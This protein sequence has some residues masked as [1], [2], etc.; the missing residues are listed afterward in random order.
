MSSRPLQ[1]NKFGNSGSSSATKYGY[2]K[3][4]NGKEKFV[5]GAA[6]AR[7]NAARKIRRKGNKILMPGDKIRSQQLIPLNLSPFERFFAGLLKG[8][9][10]DFLENDVDNWSRICIRLRLPVP[11]GPIKHYYND[12]K[13]HFSY[14]AALVIEEARYGIAQGIK[15]WQRRSKNFVKA[16]NMNN[17]DNR[18]KK[19]RNQNYNSRRG[20]VKNSIILTLTGA[21]VREKTGHCTM[22]FVKEGGAKFTL[23]EVKSLRQGTVFAC[24]NED[25]APTVANSVL[26]CLLSANREEIIESK[27]F[28]IMVFKPVKKSTDSTWQLIP[29]ASLLTEQRKFDACTSNITSTVPFLLP[30]LGGKK[31]THIKFAEK[32][33]GELVPED[34]KMEEEEK[35]SEQELFSHDELSPLFRSPPL[36]TTQKKAA[37]TFLNSQANTITLIQGPPGTG[38]TT[39]LVNIICQYVMQSITGNRARCLMVCAPTNKAVSVL[40]TRFLDTFDAAN[41]LPCNVLLVGDDDKLLDDEQSRSN[42]GRDSSAMRSIFLYTWIKTVVNR[43]SVIQKFVV[44]PMSNRKERQRILDL[45][46]NL[47]RRL[48]QSL[49][50]FPEDMGNSIDRVVTLLDDGISTGSVSQKE[51]LNIL[52]AIK[53][54]MLD[55]KPNSIWQDLLGS[56]HIIFCTLAS[57]GAGVL[58]RSI[59]EVD[60]LIVDEAAASCE[61]EMYIPF[62]F[63]PQRL[64]A[65]GDPKQLPAT[66]LSRLAAERGLEKS[67]HERLM[68][69][70]KYPHIMLDVQYRMNPEISSFPCRHFYDSKVFNGPNVMRRDYTGPLLL[71]GQSFSF[72]QVNGFE[73]QSKT[74]S[75]ENFAEAQAVVALVKEASR[76]MLGRWQ[77][78]DRIRIITFYVA[79]VTLIKR[80]LYQSGISDV[81]V[82]TVDSSQGSEADIVILSFVRSRRDRNAPVGF[83]TDDRRMNVAITRAKYQLICIGNAQQMSTLTNPNAQTVKALASNAIERN[84]VLS[85]LSSNHHQN[86]KHALMDTAIPARKKRPRDSI[87][88][89]N[90]QENRVSGRNTATSVSTADRK[91]NLPPIRLT[92]AEKSQ[93]KDS[94]ANHVPKND[95]HKNIIKQ[96]AL[97]SN[98]SIIDLCSSNSEISDSS[99]SSSSLSS[100][101]SSSSNDPDDNDDDEGSHKFAS[102]YRIENL[103]KITAGG[104]SNSVETNPPRTFVVDVEQKQTALEEQSNV[105]NSLPSQEEESFEFDQSQDSNDDIAGV[106][107]TDVRL[108]LDNKSVISDSDFVW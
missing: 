86:P 99:S 71:D 76:R 6:V 18:D 83:L 92:K 41:Q 94:K 101:S 44:R 104:L 19:S 63:K 95:T 59:G 67:L 3:T 34:V 98:P 55:W 80:L 96:E 32:E 82:A 57:S 40:C 79:Q 48:R 29:V 61:P 24:V 51:A 50:Q 100:D 36:N 77:S 106:E 21:E 58:K 73:K 107:L 33:N 78:A 97:S 12:K 66:V 105:D 31:P 20:Q 108:N 4:S 15:E 1:A 72:I 11:T 42:Q 87:S 53:D 69:D 68:D 56:A 81:V 38:K 39:L 27:S 17:H 2:V 103:G 8:E 45:A 75:Y 10:S 23:D 93:E 70:S 49:S 13:L 35:D 60:D 30:L 84:R 91:V 65:V 22:K 52:A 74:G 16:K 46:K 25:F 85:S 14:R 54:E 5:G 26:G 47:A 88:Y 43:L 62:Y 9:A 37:S 64:L 89:R 28:S 90:S 7:I 102:R